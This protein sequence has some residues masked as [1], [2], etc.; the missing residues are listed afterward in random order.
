MRRTLKSTLTV[1]NEALARVARV[2]WQVLRPSPRITLSEWADSKRR[3]SSEGSAEP[4]HWRTSRAEYMR[5]IMDA[6]TDPGV[7]KVVVMKGAQVGWTETILNVVGYYADQDP[8]PILTVQPTVGLACI[9]SKE[10]LAPML[11]DTPALREK[12]ADPRSR[13]RSNALRYKEFA[14]GYLAIIGAN[15]PSELAMRPVKVVLCDEVDRYP[16]SA[17]IEGDPMRLAEQRQSTF[18]NRKM[19]AGSTPTTEAESKINREYQRSDMRRFRV[20]CPFCAADQTLDWSQ[21]KFDKAGDASARA[22]TAFY[23]C[24]QCGEL[25][26]DVQ[27]WRAVSKGKWL[28]TQPFNGVAGFHLSQL[29][30]P[31]IRLEKIVKQFL[32]AEGNV[33]ELQVFT[34]TVLG[35]VWKEQ[36]ESADPEGL[37]RHVANYG[38]YDVPDGA[39]FATAGIDVQG[40][41]LECEIVAWGDNGRSWGV[42]Y[43]VIHGDPGQGQVWAALDALLLT[44]YWT[45]DGHLI[46]VRSACID[47][48]GH[49]AAA[50]FKFCKSRFARNVHPIKGL[51]GP[52]PVWPLRASKDK[53]RRRLWLVGVDTAKDQ[54]YGQFRIGEPGPGYCAFPPSYDAEWYIQAT[55]ETVV[56]RFRVGRPY[57]VWILPPGR[58]NEALDC[59]VYALA[60]Y[61]SL[62]ETAKKRSK[63]TAERDEKTREVVRRTTTDDAHV[64]PAVVDAAVAKRAVRRPVRR[65]R[66][67]GIH[68]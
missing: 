46:R 3:L 24:V 67:G 14:G 35:E 16:A 55:V 22:A 38:P 8:S 6:V 15:A 43:D 56:T 37:R 50:V 10:R 1:P 31:W 60:A 68:S 64:A 7:P 54:I 29:Y 36:G 48:G 45:E 58:R 39:L 2:C 18:W 28:P 62:P 4:G 59:R 27:R 66:F 30:S 26:N 52:H 17:G 41:R 33:H 13:A 19:L 42:R 5:G 11:R 12:F 65:M 40:D 32:E 20:P 44:K 49:H 61:N 53:E 21:V 57:R 51:A 34:N 23:Q 9:W 63:V 47:T 25:W